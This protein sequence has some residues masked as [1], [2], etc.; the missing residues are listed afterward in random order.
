M[1][2]VLP[3]DLLNAMASSQ[4]ILCVLPLKGFVLLPTSDGF[5]DGAL[6]HM[7]LLKIPLGAEQDGEISGY[8]I[9]I[10]GAGWLSRLSVCLWADHDPGFWD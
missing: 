9:H 2:L 4:V 7:R 1:Q 3:Y 5:D 8:K 10:L 6:G